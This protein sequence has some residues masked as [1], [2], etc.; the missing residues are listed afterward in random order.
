MGRTCEILHRATNSGGGGVK[1]ITDRLLSGA[2][3]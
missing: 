1:E 3:L 2:V